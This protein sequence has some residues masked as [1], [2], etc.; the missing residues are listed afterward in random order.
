MAGIKPG[1]Q[2]L[3]RLGLGLPAGSQTDRVAGGNESPVGLD[4]LDANR[5]GGDTHVFFASGWWRSH[6]SFFMAKR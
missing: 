4:D 5:A 3:Q 6:Q 2:P 1:L